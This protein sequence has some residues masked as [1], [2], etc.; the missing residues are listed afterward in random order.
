MDALEKE[1]N[2]RTKVIAVGKGRVNKTLGTAFLK[3]CDQL[4]FSL[5]KKLFQTPVEEA[6]KT[7]A[8]AKMRPCEVKLG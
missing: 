5:K 6:K 3:A 7:L 8:N 4:E 2:A 1:T